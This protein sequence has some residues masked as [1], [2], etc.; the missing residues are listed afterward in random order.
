EAIIS[1][2]AIPTSKEQILSESDVVSLHIPLSPETFHLIG[3]KEISMMKPTA[4]IINTSRGGIVDDQALL[5]ALRK[6]MIRGAGLDCLEHEPMR[7][8]EPLAQM[9]NVSITPHIGGTTEESYSRGSDQAV[10]EVLRY[11]EGKPLLNVFRL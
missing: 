4:F 5:E 9:Y 1:F 3:E 6:N 11:L 8:D 10:A 7:K 2:G